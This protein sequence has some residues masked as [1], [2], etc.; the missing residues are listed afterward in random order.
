[1]KNPVF[2]FKDLQGQLIS[3]NSNS[4]IQTLSK[5]YQG[6]NFV[7]I[8][9]CKEHKGVGI[10]HKDHQQKNA[11]RIQKRQT[12]LEKI[13][14]GS[15]SDYQAF[16]TQNEQLPVGKL[17]KKFAEVNGILKK[18]EKKEK[19]EKSPQQEDRK[20]ERKRKILEKIFGGEEKN[21]QEQFLKENKDLKLGELIKK[22]SEI[23]GTKDNM[24]NNEKNSLKKKERI[25]EKLSAVL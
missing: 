1:M 22:Y 8:L 12:I 14:G 5:S 21:K 20:F 10:E 23:N 25:L 7:Q 9:I 11:N 19:K 6:Q 13:Y 15:G 17:I 2:K 3:I 24:P 4:D 18:K 16:V